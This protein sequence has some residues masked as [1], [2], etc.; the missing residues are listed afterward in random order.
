MIPRTK[1]PAELFA[2][3]ERQAGV[4]SREQAAAHGISDRVRHRFVEIG[5]WQPLARGVY[6]A[7]A[8]PSWE[9]LAWAGILI[10]GD[11]AGLIGRAAAHL[12]GLVSTP[13]ATIEIGLPAGRR[14]VDREPWEFRQR[15]LTM[16]GEPPAIGVDD[17]VLDL[18]QGADVERMTAVLADAVGGRRTTVRRLREA[19]DA[20]AA[21]S[22]RRRLLPILREVGDGTH[23]LL[24]RRYTVDVERAH[25]LP[26]ARRQRHSGIH[27]VD[28]HYTEY[29]L[30]VELDGRE[31]HS[32]SRLRAD[33]R[34]DNAHLGQGLLTLRFGWPDV[35]QS[36]CAT[37]VQVA[38]LLIRLGWTGLPPRC[39]RCERAPFHP[40]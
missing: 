22:G 32:G 36:P 13:P 14:R 9:G 1:A 15:T 20:R 25:G 19:L 26:A 23:S 8:R 38:E 37:A 39:R 4:I 30:I 5:L 21:Y 24:E 35:T 11:G 31:F 7:R 33:A 6:W 28:N 18:C 10:G 34:R 27:R 29:Q 12:H 3:A 40:G 17:A 2:L 16:V